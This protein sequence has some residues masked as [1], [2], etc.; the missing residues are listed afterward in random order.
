[1]WRPDVARFRRGELLRQAFASSPKQR[2]ASPHSERC[3]TGTL[4]DSGDNKSLVQATIGRVVSRI[5]NF[6]TDNG[7]EETSLNAVS[8]FSKGS[9]APHHD[10]DAL[11]FT[12]VELG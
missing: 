5:K 2:I 6:T 10:P 4:N 12:F 11:A 7:C 3:F 8:R 9:R 1:M